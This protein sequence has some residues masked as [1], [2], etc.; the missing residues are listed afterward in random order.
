ML[1]YGFNNDLCYYDRLKSSFLKIY[2]FSYIVV[3]ILRINCFAR[4]GDKIENK[5]RKANFT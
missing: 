4:L 2:F 3:L 5:L 1:K